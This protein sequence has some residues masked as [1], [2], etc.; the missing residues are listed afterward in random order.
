MDPSI[1]RYRKF[2]VQADH[3]ASE[4]YDK[5]VMT[6]SGGTL[7]ISL[8]FIKDVV[9]TPQAGTTWL[10]FAAWEFLALSIT[11]ILASM[12][13]SQWALRKAIDQ[14]DRDEIRRRTPGGWFTWITSG[15]SIIAGL[16]FVLG[17]VFLARFA[18]SNMQ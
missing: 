16:A 18:I 7:A 4:A 8:T 2:L 14:V 9:P 6:L 5:A 1:D 3:K 12:L 10:L 17:V 11:A 13:T 15:L